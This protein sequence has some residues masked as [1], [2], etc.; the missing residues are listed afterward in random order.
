MWT[1]KQNVV[2][3][4]SCGC[5]CVKED[6]E[7][8]GHRR[9]L[10]VC[11]SRKLDEAHMVRYEEKNGFLYPTDLGRIASLFYIKYATVEV[12]CLISSSHLLLSAVVVSRAYTLCLC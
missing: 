7:L 10:I 5:C 6:G 3:V 2:N 11:A 9:D 1:N 4:L 12:S 8:E